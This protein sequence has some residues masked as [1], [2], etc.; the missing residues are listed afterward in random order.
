MNHHATELHYIKKGYEYRTY[1]EQ[2]DD[3]QKLF[4]YC[5][6]DGKEIDMGV[7]FYNESPYELMSPE[8]FGIYVNQIEVFIQG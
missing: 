4:H 2:E 7:N 1:L 3:N 6:K 5:F 8:L